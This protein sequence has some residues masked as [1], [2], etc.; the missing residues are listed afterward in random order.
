MIQ[1]KNDRSRR[2]LEAL[3]REA[4]DID[5][6]A[7]LDRTIRARAAEASGKA[8]TPRRLPWLG[9]LAAASV[10][11]VSIAVVLQQSPPGQPAHKPATPLERRAP[12]ALMVPSLGAQ[13]GDQSA[14]DS[15]GKSSQTRQTRPHTPTPAQ[16]FAAPSGT[17]HSEAKDDAEM[18]LQRSRH[19]H[20]LA[21]QPGVIAEPARKIPRIATDVGEDPESMLKLIQAMIER[22]EI[23]RAREQFER[24]RRQFPEHPIP[25]NIDQILRDAGLWIQ[26]SPGPADSPR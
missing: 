19:E 1:T 14:M 8:R 2:E 16:S 17:P 21:E 24:F 25:E 15:S 23:Q 11:L 7:G 4:G 20:F 18:Q 10:A 3:Y 26:G 12:E 5:P 22:D 6:E 9:G 13:S